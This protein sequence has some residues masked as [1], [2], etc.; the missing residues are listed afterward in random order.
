MDNT[1]RINERWNRVIL[2]IGL[3]LVRIFRCAGEAIW[4]GARISG[5]SWKA[6]PGLGPWQGLTG[7]FPETLDLA[8]A[9]ERRQRAAPIGCQRFKPSETKAF[10][11]GAEDRL[12]WLGDAVVVAPNS[13]TRRP[14][15]RQEQAGAHA[16]RGKRSRI[17]TDQL[18]LSWAGWRWRGFGARGFVL[19]LI[20]SA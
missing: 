8:L 15:H 2:F 6:H 10:L 13:T 5:P 18:T 12:N 4:C 11:G 17:G 3:V 16:L 19:I 9:V 14:A 7:T 1:R 20:C